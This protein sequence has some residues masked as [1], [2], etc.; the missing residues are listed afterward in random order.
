MVDYVLRER[1]G[2]LVSDALRDERFQAVQSI[3][4]SGVREVICVPMKGRH[5]TLGVL[6]LDTSTP[7]TALLTARPLGKFTGDHLA[8]AI[9]IAHQAA[10][11]V[12]ETLSPGGW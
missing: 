6:Y 3:V 12:E 8:L 10:L 7:A 1:K 9:A 11:A 4:R 5:Q 2:I